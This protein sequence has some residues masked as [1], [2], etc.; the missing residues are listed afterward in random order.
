MFR[1]QNQNHLFLQYNDINTDTELLGI[2][3]PETHE[4]H[5]VFDKEFNTLVEQDETTLPTDHSKSEFPSSQ[6]LHKAVRNIQV[7]TEQINI[8]KFRH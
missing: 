3:T 4:L 5:K 1:V 7:F 6:I 2:N 8:R